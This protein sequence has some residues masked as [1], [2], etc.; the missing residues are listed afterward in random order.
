VLANQ[1]STQIPYGAPMNETLHEYLTGA[2]TWRAPTAPAI[3]GAVAF[4]AGMIMAGVRYPGE[5]DWR[6]MTIS[7]LTS[8]ARNPAGHLWAS[9][10]MLL[11]FVSGLLWV[12]RLARNWNHNAGIALRGI[13][14]LRVGV[15]F[16]ACVAVLPSSLI[17]I[18]KGHEILAL[19]AFIGWCVGMLQLTFQTAE[20][21]L[22]RRFVG[23]TQCARICAA[24]LVGAAVF[25]LFLAGLTQAYVRYALPEL[26]WVN[27]SWRAQGVPAYLSFASWEW[28]TCAVLSVYMVGLSLTAHVETDDFGSVDSEQICFS[29]NNSLERL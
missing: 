14:L 28:V 21:V 12:T 22:R 5:F 9:G 23:G 26:R 1:G 11:C 10:G 20:Q 8:P 19:F 27:L 2:S 18:R 4:W 6:Y 7:N 24:A 25:P 16:T 3:L 29:R 15:I 13:A 17:R